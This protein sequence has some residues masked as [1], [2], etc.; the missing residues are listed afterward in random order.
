MLVGEVTQ[1]KI[2]SKLCSCDC[3]I[4]KSL[5]EKMISVEKGGN[6]VFWSIGKNYVLNVVE[7]VTSEYIFLYIIIVFYCTSIGDVFPLFGDVIIVF[8]HA[9]I[10]R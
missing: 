3:R 10:S 4:G 1:S 8:G 6:K 7:N 5:K 9:R 2:H